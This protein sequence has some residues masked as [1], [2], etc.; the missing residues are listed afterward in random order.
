MFGF[1]SLTFFP[2]FLGLVLAN[3][4]TPIGASDK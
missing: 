1:G 2:W 3:E 4:Q